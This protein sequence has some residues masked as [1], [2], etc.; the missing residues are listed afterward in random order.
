MRVSRCS[1]VQMYQG[2]GI[3]HGEREHP[4]ATRFACHKDTMA[5]ALDAWCERVWTVCSFE[6]RGQLHC[7]GHLMSCQSVSCMSCLLPTLAAIS[8]RGI[9]KPHRK[10]WDWPRHW[11]FVVLWFF[12]DFLMENHGTSK[13]IFRNGKHISENYRG[14]RSHVVRARIQHPS[15]LTYGQVLGKGNLPAT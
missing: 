5:D 15:F 9:S 11:C 13:G 8:Q 7:T 1:L 4:Q 2:W 6:K 3:L 14:I 12:F 10:T